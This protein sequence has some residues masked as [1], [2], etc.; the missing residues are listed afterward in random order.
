MKKLETFPKTAY[1]LMR[2]TE[3]ELEDFPAVHILRYQIIAFR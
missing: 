3:R 1:E 2:E